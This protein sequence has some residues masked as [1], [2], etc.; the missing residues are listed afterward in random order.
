[1]VGNLIGLS[2]ESPRIVL[3]AVLLCIAGLLYLNR[4]LYRF[5]WRKRGAAFAMQAVA[6]H[7]LYLFYSGSVFV[8]CCIAALLRSP[9]R[10]PIAVFSLE[11]RLIARARRRKERDYY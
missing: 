1:M 11:S 4:G 6:A 7:W 9:F 3:S 2:R 8:L 10:P 5:F